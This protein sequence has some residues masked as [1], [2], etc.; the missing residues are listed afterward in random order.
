MLAI[1]GLHNGW[2]HLVLPIAHSDE[3][4]MDVVLTVSSFHLSIDQEGSTSPQRKKSTFK[5]PLKFR[6]DPERL[7]SSV[8]AGLQKRQ[9]QLGVCNN[10]DSQFT[11]LAIVVLLVVVMVT[12]S[13]DFPIL[14]RMMLA[15]FEAVGGEAGLGKGELAQFMIRQIHKSVF[16]ILSHRFGVKYGILIFC[17][18]PSIRSPIHR[19]RKWFANS[20][21]EATHATGI[22]MPEPLFRAAPR[23]C[24]RSTLHHQPRPAS[25]RHL[26]SPSP[27]HH[28][29]AS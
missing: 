13:D 18:T 27:I 15:A 11:L 26:P 24:Y 6:P 10:T 17:Q 5:V 22:R 4:L 28:I 16:T 12:G 3:L 19:R 14:Y 29:T 25:T 9:E 1:D 23:G 2:R 20:F 7:Y 21:F 8:I